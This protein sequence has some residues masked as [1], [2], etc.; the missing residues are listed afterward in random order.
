MATKKDLIEAQNYSRARLLS[1]F[2]GGAPGGKELEPA[3][4]L[5][6]VVAGILLTAMLVL[7]GVFYGLVQPGL[8]A[9]WQNNRLIL[10]SDTGARYVSIKGIL[11]P[12]INTASAR[13]LI[14]ADKLSIIT[15]KQKT[16]G[17]IKIGG[18][19]GIL[20]A[21][22]RL[23]S[24]T[25]LHESGWAAC[26]ISGVNTS[27]S[28]GKTSPAAARAQA[29]VVSVEKQVWVVTGEHR[30]EVDAGQVT[31]VL[32]AIGLDG[33]TA[34]PV[35]GRWLNLFSPGQ[36]LKAITISRVGQPISHSTLTVGSI[37]HRE[38]SPAKQRFVVTA[39]GNL[40]ALSPLAYQ[41]YLLGS[42][43]GLEGDTEV[44]P[45]EIASLSTAERP[46]G[47][48]DWPTE[49]LDVIGSA[50]SPCALLSHK[51]KSPVT[52]LGTTIQTNTDRAS[53]NNKN[54]A[55]NGGALIRTGGSGTAGLVYLIDESGTA[56]P[57][58]GANEDIIGRLGYS[59]K[60]I[61]RVPAV[62]LAFLPVGPELSEKAAGQTPAPQAPAT[63]TPATQER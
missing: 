5:R 37:I 33:S 34:A 57:V 21:P 13:L 25:A 1:A 49:T 46:A 41:L 29:A 55:P 43:A 18:T 8:P 27:I 6:A 19:I 38:G 20:G 53:E 56:F 52:T 15:T 42:G 16:L 47:G 60:D 54:V 2:T 48:S 36:P 39:D 12:V 10:V 31:A 40:A 22:D 44:K 35:D 3:K 11:Y 62:W 26:S 24:A 23:P 59:M 9:G 50:S 30:Y 45:A 17:D 61:L 7:G 51:S 14:P 32:R 63:Q 28:L 4:P 58:P